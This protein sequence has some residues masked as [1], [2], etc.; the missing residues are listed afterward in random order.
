LIEHE[1]TTLNDGQTFKGDFAVFNGGVTTDAE[2]RKIGV[3]L[4]IE[5]QVEDAVAKWKKD[6]EA[7][8]KK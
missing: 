2:G 1:A 3:L 7:A 5:K 4:T 8:K 6:R